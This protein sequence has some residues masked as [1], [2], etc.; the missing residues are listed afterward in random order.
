MMTNN[1][2]SPLPLFDSMEY[3]KKKILFTHLSPIQHEDFL[4]CIEFLKNYAGSLGTF[5]SYRREIERFLYW[6]WIVAKNL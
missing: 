2:L 6:T 3:I 1:K 5:N 4:I